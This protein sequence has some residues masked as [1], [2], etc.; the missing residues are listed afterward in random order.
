[1]SRIS[2]PR[3]IDVQEEESLIE[4][5]TR[6]TRRMI[7]GFMDFATQGNI[8]EIA[9]GLILAQ[10]FTTVVT[11]FVSDI[12]LPPLSVILPLNANLDLKFAV[13]Q[14][15]PNYLRWGGY[16]TIEQAQD[17]GAVIMAYGVFLNKTINF[18]GLGLALYSL[19]SFYE[20]L[21]SDPIVKRTVKCPY[22]K[23]H[24]NEKA[25]RCVNCTS[26]LDGRENRVQ[27]QSLLSP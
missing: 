18:I 20:Y 5:G 14:P 4:Y 21:S 23:K 26:W 15:G 17:D 13:L 6:K 1:M 10:A 2:L 3:L 25:M 8:L 24:I 11:S 12:L 16:N 27:V 19:A 22:C 9:F 7:D